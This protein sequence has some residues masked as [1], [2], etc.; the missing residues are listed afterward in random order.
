LLLDFVRSKEGKF[1]GALVLSILLLAAPVA[2][3]KNIY[4]NFIF[5][6]FLNFILGYLLFKDMKNFCKRID[7][8]KYKIFARLIVI[9]VAIAD[10]FFV[11][12][13]TVYCFIGSL[14]YN[15]I[16]FLK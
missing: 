13:W 9:I 11:F 16:I 2:S 3:L 14:W 12:G 8:R 7:K 1:L 10:Y 4:A 15:K 6:V 5:A